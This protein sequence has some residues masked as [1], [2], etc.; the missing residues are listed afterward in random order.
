MISFP[1]EEIQDG[2]PCAEKHKLAYHV[3]PDKGDGADGS[4]KE[5]S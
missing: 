3:D 2:H 4:T 1:L 5:A